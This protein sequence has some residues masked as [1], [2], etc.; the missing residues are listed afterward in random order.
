[1]AEKAATRPTEICK[2]SFYYIKALKHNK[3]KPKSVFQMQD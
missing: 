1:M 2:G 3:I